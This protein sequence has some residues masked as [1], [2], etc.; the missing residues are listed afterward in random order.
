V[1]VVCGIG[2]SQLFLRNVVRRA[3]F[4]LPVLNLL[5]PE[6]L[7]DFEMIRRTR[8]TSVCELDPP[9]LSQRDCETIDR[10]MRSATHGLE[11][12]A[13]ADPERIK[14]SSILSGS[15]IA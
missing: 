1:R 9:A 14:D 13:K 8:S 6:K 12:L 10:S 5:E 2:S 11:T 15:R 7:S 3:A 4:Y